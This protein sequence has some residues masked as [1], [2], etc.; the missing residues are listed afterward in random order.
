MIEERIRWYRLNDPR[1]DRLGE[2]ASFRLQA[3]GRSVRV[4][5]TGGVLYAMADRCPHQGKGFE[6]GHVEEGYWV[7][8]WHRFAFDPATGRSRHGSCANVEVFPLEH[9]PDGW[10]LGMA[11][12]TIT[13]FGRA[14]W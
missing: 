1:L 4:L 7:C 5:R 14:L 12:T 13:F 8:P 9:H 11:Y 6:G 3:G 10:R 2:G